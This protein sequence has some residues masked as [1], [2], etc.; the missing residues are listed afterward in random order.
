MWTTNSCIQYR[1]QVI[2]AVP[3]ENRREILQASYAPEDAGRI[4][5]DKIQANALQ[6]YVTH[7]RAIGVGNCAWV[8]L[9]HGREGRRNVGRH[10]HPHAA[11]VE[12][13]AQSGGD[14]GDS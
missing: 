6:E 14:K 9:L 3:V 5:K 7:A 1:A 13:L 12:V 8:A 10:R 4:V 11:D 2:G